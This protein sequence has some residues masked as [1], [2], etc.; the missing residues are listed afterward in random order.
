MGA[1]SEW[2]VN[3]V[4]SVV[5]R[6]GGATSCKEVGNRMEITRS[7]EVIW[8]GS[9]KDGSGQLN[10]DSG[11]GMLPFTWPSRMR[12]PQGR[13][14]PEELLAAAQATCY[15]MALS[16]TLSELGAPTE[17]IRVRA[18][19]TL[20]KSQ[21]GTRISRMDIWGEA[22]N[23]EYGPEV[24]T[25]AVK[26]AKERCPVSNAFDPEMDFVLHCSAPT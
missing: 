2:T 5:A 20:D 6:A 15:V 4:D 16:N 21:S 3:A 12:D 8:K 1:P 14:S 13:T 9:L 7:V 26:K 18:A 11:A 19:C 10:L 22:L 24:F 25:S 17:S 23:S